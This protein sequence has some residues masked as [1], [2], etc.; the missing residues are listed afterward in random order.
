MLSPLGSAVLDL[1]LA[2][3]APMARQLG[4][5]PARDGL[6]LAPRRLV[7]VLAISSSG[8]LARG[9]PRISSEVRHLI[10]RMARE[11]SLWGAPRIHGKLQMLGLSVSPSHGVAL[12]ACSKQT[13][14]AIVADFCSQS[15]SGV[16][17]TRV[18]RGAVGDGRCPAHRVMSGPS[19]SD[20]GRTNCK[21]MGWAQAQ[22]LESLCG[23]LSAI[24]E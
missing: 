7:S 19:S 15:S 12:H 10:L 23:P 11:N 2:L 21:R 9:A 16:Q 3:V 17:S 24:A 18:R 4:H 8:S 22:L 14:S 13:A 20:R 5:C 1:V 6:A